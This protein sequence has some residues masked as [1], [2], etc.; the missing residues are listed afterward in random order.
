MISIEEVTSRADSD[1][2][3]AMLCIDT[4]KQCKIREIIT[5]HMFL[6]WSEALPQ[7]CECSSFPALHLSF[8][9][10]PIF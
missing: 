3:S 10:T 6:G 1:S 4:D 5:S 8:Q 7:P 2:D 9:P